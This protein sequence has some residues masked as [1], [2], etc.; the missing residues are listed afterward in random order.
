M[1]QGQRLQY[2]KLNLLSLK[3]TGAAVKCLW[4]KV[5][6]LLPVPTWEL[7][8]ACWSERGQRPF[9]HFNSIVSCIPMSKEAVWKSWNYYRRHRLK[10]L[11]G[12]IMYCTSVCTC[13]CEGECNFRLCGHGFLTRQALLSIEVTV[14]LR[15]PM[16]TV[17]WP[18]GWQ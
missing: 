3:I 9:W 1:C 6:G 13:L 8:S 14:I 10:V 4:Q 18:G 17:I 7:F 12:E 11:Q 2:W 15:G 5:C 16:G